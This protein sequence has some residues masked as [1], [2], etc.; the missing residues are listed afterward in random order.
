MTLNKIIRVLFVL[1]LPYFFLNSSELFGQQLPQELLKFF[2]YRSIGPTR[3]GGRIVDF[4]VSLQQSNTF[5]TATANGGRTWEKSLSVMQNGR[6]IGAVD[7][8]MYPSNPTILYAPS[9]DRIAKP[10][11]FYEG[12]SGGGIH[13]TTDGGK[14]WTKLFNGLPSENIGRIGLTIFPQNPDI[15]YAYILEDRNSDGR[16]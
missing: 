15:L 14:S 7:L 8:V 16:Y 2:H 10:W 1:M 12:G 13:K 11:M 6:D 5:Y 3:Q 9:Y 4:A